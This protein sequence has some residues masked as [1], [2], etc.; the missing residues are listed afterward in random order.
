MQDEV[1]KDNNPVME[2]LKSEMKVGSRVYMGIKSKYFRLLGS[3]VR[4][5]EP[6]SAQYCHAP[7]LPRWLLTT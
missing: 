5:P 2:R 4:D 1:V 7:L 3:L 6:V